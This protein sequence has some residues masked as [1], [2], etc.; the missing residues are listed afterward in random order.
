MIYRKTGYLEIFFIEE[1]PFG[2]QMKSQKI[3]S[4][5]PAQNNGKKQV[6]DAGDCIF[7]AVNI[8]VFHAF[9]AKER[10]KE[11]GCSQNM[12]QMT[13]SKKNF[14]YS[15]ETASGGEDLSL[16]AFSA[17]DQKTKFVMSHQ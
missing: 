6:T 15:F 4:T 7:S 14:I 12:I 11:S 8:H 3:G 2:K 17:I 1:N 5:I 16:S 9:P 13:V 10:W